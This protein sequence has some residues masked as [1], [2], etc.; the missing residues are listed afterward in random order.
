M[1]ERM[2]VVHVREL[3]LIVFSACAHAGVVN[4]RTHTRS[5]FPEIP[6]YCV[7]GGLHLG[8]V[9]EAIIPTL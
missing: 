5:L 9:M 7:M 3:G 6:T 4:V 1:D 8:G 2:L